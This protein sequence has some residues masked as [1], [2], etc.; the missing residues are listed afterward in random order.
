MKNETRKRKTPKKYR[1]HK[2]REKMQT[3]K[4]T[5]NLKKN[6]EKKIEA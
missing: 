1:N 6:K 3:A 2:N 4:K 5:R